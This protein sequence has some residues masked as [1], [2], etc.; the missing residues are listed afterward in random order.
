MPSTAVRS[1]AGSEIYIL[2]ISQSSK[3][4]TTSWPSPMVSRN[5]KI[6]K[7]PETNTSQLT[8][9]YWRAALDWR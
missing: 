8:K 6:P 3:Q 9:L 4:W 1:D 2:M 7:L 5:L